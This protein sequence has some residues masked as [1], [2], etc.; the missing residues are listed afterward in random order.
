[1]IT[2]KDVARRAGVSITTVSHVV[3][4]TRFV[5]EATRTRVLEAISALNYVPSAVARSLKNNRTQ[6]VG[7]I[8]P[9]ISN[10]FFA[11]VVRGI[12]DGC[13]AL[14]VN[15]ILCNS[16]DQVDKQARYLRSLAEKQVDGII[17]FS[18]GSSADVARDLDAL[19]M[20]KVVVDREVGTVSA[21]HVAVDQELGGYL[22]TRHLIDL[23][24]RRIACITGSAGLAPT[25]ARVAGWTRA[26]NEAGLRPSAALLADGGFTSEGGFRAAQRFLSSRSVPT[27]IFASNDL[28]ALGALCAAGLA[29]IGVPDDLSVVGVDDIAL[30][31]YA[32]PP[33]TTV[34]QPKYDVGMLTAQLICE[35]IANAA[36]PFQ[37]RLLSPSLITR[38]S[39][40]APRKVMA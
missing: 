26:L 2:I 40:A 39:T 23:G 15:V 27:A 17:V 1:M 30:A 13:W 36:L 16:D 22:A 5:G 29:G 12:E 3:N 38:R 7:V 11:E 8:T 25:Q 31:E 9:N 19:P 4:A 24:H 34:A 33:L 35:R 14:G 32:N 10:P 18:S 20:P 21:D 6:S 37:R 28:M